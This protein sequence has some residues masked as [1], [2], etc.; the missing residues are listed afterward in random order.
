MIMQDM[1]WNF[2]ESH[3]GY[4]LRKNP[5][6]RRPRRVRVLL[7]RS[8]AG[9]ETRAPAAR[10]W[11]LRCRGG[12]ASRKGLV[13]RPSTHPW[14]PVRDVCVFYVCSSILSHSSSSSSSTFMWDYGGIDRMT[15]LLN[16]DSSRKRQLLVCQNT[17]F[18]HER[19]LMMRGGMYRREVF[20]YE[21]R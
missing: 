20:S 12:E 5:W 21:K 19:F 2:T 6:Q 14:E 17:R 13:R 18:R 7:A 1:W 10:Q 16:Y 4:W 11:D 8:F 15:W 9:V 3:L